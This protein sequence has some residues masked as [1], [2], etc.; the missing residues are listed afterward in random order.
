MNNGKFLKVTG[1]KIKAARRLRKVTLMQ[2]SKS[3]GVNIT[4]L[5]FLENGKSNPHLLTIKSIAD[6]LN[7]DV[8]EF[9]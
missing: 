9:I 1:A 4:A 2:L 5:S 3:C 8:K 6:V 7:V